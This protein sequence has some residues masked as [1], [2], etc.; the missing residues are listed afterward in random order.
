MTK[1]VI[2]SPLPVP[3]PRRCT[4]PVRPCIPTTDQDGLSAGEMSIA[5]AH[6]GR[7]P[8]TTITSFRKS[9][10]DNGGG[11]HENE[12]WGSILVTPPFLLSPQVGRCYCHL[13][14]PGEWLMAM[15]LSKGFTTVRT[16]GL[17]RVMLRLPA[18]CQ[19]IITL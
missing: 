15:L 9:Q 5:D 18:V 2:S 3:R 10:N 16:S 11:T 4:H 12:G 7:G 6:Q 8:R 14:Y 19:S 1:L 17:L 13:S